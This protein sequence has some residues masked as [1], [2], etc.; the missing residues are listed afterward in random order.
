MKKDKKNALIES[1]YAFF[2]LDAKALLELQDSNGDTIVFPDLYEN[3][4]FSEGDKV[5]KDGNPADGEILMPDGKKVIA[6]EGVVKE[7]IEAE[8]DDE[9]EEQE[10][11][12]AE[13]EAEAKEAEKAELVDVLAKFEKKIIDANEKKI[14]SLEKEILALKKNTGS[15][16]DN[17]PKG[18]ERKTESKFFSASRA[19]QNKRNKNKK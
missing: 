7:I 14:K 5:E 17:E 1:F 15:K 9:Q 18:T 2:N 11:A 4:T 3:D 13:A 8:S 16:I 19:I 10:D 12:E 6:E